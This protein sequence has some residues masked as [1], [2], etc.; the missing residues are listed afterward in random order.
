M[1]SNENVTLA[2]I[3]NGSD[4][5]GIKS[6]KENRSEGLTAGDNE[7]TPASEGARKVAQGFSTTNSGTKRQRTVTPAAFKAIGDDEE[8][9][10]SPT[11]RKMAQCKSDKESER[12]ILSGLENVR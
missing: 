8:V 3:Q 10:S 6:R 12:R 5:G 11:T 1:R 4:V 2:P 7:A 9:K